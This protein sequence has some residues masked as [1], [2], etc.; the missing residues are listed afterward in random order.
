MLGTVDEI[1][2]DPGDL[3]PRRLALVVLVAALMT[4]GVGAGMLLTGSGDRPVADG[5]I[6]N[7]VRPRHDHA[8]P[9][10][11]PPDVAPAEQLPAAPAANPAPPAA[12]VPPPAP[13]APHPVDIPIVIGPEPAVPI[14]VPAAQPAS[15]PPDVPPPSD[16]AAPQDDSAPAVG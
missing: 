1:Q 5:S 11:R 15:A 4:T 2:R 14:D 7:V 8:V 10:R 3:D 9:G 13:V 16:L 6:V 12:A